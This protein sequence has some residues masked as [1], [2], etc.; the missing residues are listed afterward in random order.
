MERG[1]GVVGEIE[2]EDLV[3][4]ADQRAGVAVEI[5]PVFCA[6]GLVRVVRE[7]ALVRS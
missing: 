3:V 1:K 6:A 2:L 4:E 5:L 7:T